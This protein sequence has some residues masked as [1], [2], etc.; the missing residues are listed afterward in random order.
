MS[1]LNQH[2]TT[3]SHAPPSSLNSDSPAARLTLVCNSGAVPREFCSAAVDDTVLLPAALTHAAARAVAES[4]ADPHDHLAA[5]RRS[6]GLA[7]LRACEAG[8]KPDLVL[9]NLFSLEAW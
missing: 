7:I 6:E 1:K 4:P 2:H 5:P 3:G 8:N 9:F